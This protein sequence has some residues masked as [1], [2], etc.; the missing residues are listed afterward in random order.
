MRPV[1][2]LVAIALL[3]A[4]P[5]SGQDASGFPNQTIKIIV[6]VPAGGGVDT[7]TRIVAEKLRQ[8]FGQPVI[9]ENRGGQSGNLGAEAVF[10]AEPDGY[11]LMASQPAPLTVNALLYRKLNF[12]PAGLVPVAIMTAHPEYVDSAAELSSPHLR[13][14]SRLRARQPRQDKLRV[15]RHRHDVASDRRT[16]PDPDRHQARACALQG[17]GAGAE[18][19][20]RRPCRYDFQ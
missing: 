19:P 5:A 17:H 2:S 7:M 10:T 1:F 3:A 13:G 20:D 9:V 16:V 4:G 14:V 11:T 12:D 8:K 18:R 6:T 15:A